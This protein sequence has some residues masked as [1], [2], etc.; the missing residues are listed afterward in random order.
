MKKKNC[1]FVLK[2][3]VNILDKKKIEKEISRLSNCGFA[4][5]ILSMLL[6]LNIESQFK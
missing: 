1:H 3:G 4:F 6:L 5:S 2:A